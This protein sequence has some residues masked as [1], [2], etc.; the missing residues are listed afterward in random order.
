MSEPVSPEAA[1][2][3]VV[4]Q[5][6]VQAASLAPPPVTSLPADG[7]AAVVDVEQLL[8]RIQQL[9]AGV[10]AAQ[11]AADAAKAAAEPKPPSLGDVGINAAD[12]AARHAFQLIAEEL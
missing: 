8:A 4:D 6:G 11:A 1:Q 10:A 2:Q 9:E 5:L 12:P 7:T 3:A